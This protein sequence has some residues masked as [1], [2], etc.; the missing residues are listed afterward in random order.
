MTEL[1]AAADSGGRKEQLRRDAV[2]VGTTF[3][4]LLPSRGM[5]IPE[6]SF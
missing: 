5:G 1:M 3:L 6:A 4:Q 2:P